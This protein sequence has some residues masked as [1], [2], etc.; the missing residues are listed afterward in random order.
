MPSDTAVSQRKASMDQ[1]RLVKSGLLPCD[2]VALQNK[3]AE[4]L[5]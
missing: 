4:E 1:C 3:G 2:A 5:S